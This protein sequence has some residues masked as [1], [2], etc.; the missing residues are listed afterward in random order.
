MP[1]ATPT[2]SS[3]PSSNP[4]TSS[5]PTI[6]IIEGTFVD[7]TN[8]SI[9]SGCVA[10]PGQEQ[11][12]AVKHVMRITAEFVYVVRY[13]I[14]DADS[15]QQAKVIRGLEKDFHSLIFDSYVNCDDFMTQVR[16]LN[17]H[18]LNKP[19]GVSSL[20]IDKPAKDL[21]CADTKTGEICLPIYGGVTIIYPPES[22]TN[23]ELVVY[24][25]LEFIMNAAEDGTL[26]PSDPSIVGVDYH[27]KLGANKINPSK[28][29]V[30][31][32]KIKG[33]FGN[34]SIITPFT[35]LVAV[36]SIII[37][38]SALYVIKMKWR[39]QT[40]SKKRY[41]V[42]HEGKS[43][44]AF[45]RSAMRSTESSPRQNRLVEIES[46][47]RKEKLRSNSTVNFSFPFNLHVPVIE[48][49]DDAGSLESDKVL[50]YAPAD[51]HACISTYDHFGDV[52]HFDCAQSDELNA[53]LES[54]DASNW[55]EGCEIDFSAN[56]SRFSIP[57]DA[58]SYKIPNTI[59]M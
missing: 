9:E 4:S 47:R 52:F 8:S 17:E 59:N 12:F 56:N 30:M 51:Q 18:N 43:T 24:D 44:Y 26:T 23:S 48:V 42:L 53:D 50:Y 45:D 31:S 5:S 33:E 35:L 15:D 20:P 27:G 10:P 36:A 29:L 37:I 2:I 6:D 49:G 38:G 54:A 22:D 40:G 3:L 25:V 7:D 32:S 21:A 16:N 11:S 14:D 1:S 46:L 39:S 28:D 58:R 13:R 57:N 34:E 55:Y 41:G 19:I